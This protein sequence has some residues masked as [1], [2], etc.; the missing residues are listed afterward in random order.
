MPPT[1]QAFILQMLGPAYS[2]GDFA[3][4]SADEHFWQRAQSLAVLF[5]IKHV[6]YFRLKAAGKLADLPNWLAQDWEADYFKNGARNAVVMADLE[7]LESAFQKSGIDLLPIKG[8]A[9]F[10]AGVYDNLGLRTLSDLDVMVREQDLDKSRL[11]L[12]ELG[13]SGEKTTT[14]LTDAQYRRAKNHLRPLLSPRGVPLEV[15]WCFEPYQRSPSHDRSQIWP[16]ARQT[17]HGLV[18]SPE[19]MALQLAIHLSKADLFDFSTFAKTLLDWQALERFVDQMDLNYLREDVQ[20]RRL[21]NIWTF[22]MQAFK[23]AGYQPRI[24]IDVGRP[25][26]KTLR[27][28]QVLE[29]FLNF[30]APQDSAEA[31]LQISLLK[32]KYFWRRMAMLWRVL[33]PAEFYRRHRHETLAVRMLRIVQKFFARFWP[34]RLLGLL[35][36]AAEW[37]WAGRS[38]WILTI[39]PLYEKL[40]SLDRLAKRWSR[41]PGPPRPISDRAKMLDIA[42]WFLGLNLWAFRPTCLKRSWLYFALLRRERIPAVLHFGVRRLGTGD[43]DGHAWVSVAG[44]NISDRFEQSAQYRE[45]FRY[46]PE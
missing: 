37:R 29:A 23:A 34:K 45:T 16:R 12:H 27:A 44:E 8:A 17:P 3:L 14:S 22:C 9:F 13:Y 24:A 4:P 36:S 11:L 25:D 33:V 35:Q 32:E 6:M 10:R 46:P 21:E 5:G 20:R 7:Q 30:S 15:H 18:P 39:L 2:A 28:T 42:E 26:K 43:L 40:F 19:D 1:P 41:M 38:V 31:A